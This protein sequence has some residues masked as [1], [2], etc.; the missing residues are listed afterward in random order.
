MPSRRAFSEAQA[1]RKK[2]CPAKTSVG[3]VIAAEIQWNRSRVA[4]SAPDQTAKDSSMT[5][6]IANPATPSRISRSRPARSVAVVDRRPGSSSCAGKPAPFSAAIRSSTFTEGAA[7]TETRF[8]VR[9][10]R[11]DFTPGMAFSVRSTSEMQTAQCAVGSD[12]MMPASRSARFAAMDSAEGAA[13]QA[14]QAEI[15]V[16][17]VDISPSRKDQAAGEIACHRPKTPQAG[18]STCRAP[19]G[20]RR[21]SHRSHS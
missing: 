3:S 15:F 13:T 4:S 20:R 8:C 5:F 6:I 19:G 14:G 11:A 7:A 10:T 1:E 2:G 12:S 17:A 16:A 18:S 9:L 21:H